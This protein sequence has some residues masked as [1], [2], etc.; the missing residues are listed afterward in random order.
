MKEKSNQQKKDVLPDNGIVHSVLVELFRSKHEGIL[1]TRERLRIAMGQELGYKLGMPTDEYLNVTVSE[2]RNI[3]KEIG[4]EH[5]I[6]TIL[7]HGYRII[8]PD[9]K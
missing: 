7:G 4:S 9:E 6:K 5:K 1:A 8:S 2:L 3:L